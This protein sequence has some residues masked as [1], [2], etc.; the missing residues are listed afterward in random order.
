VRRLTVLE[1]PLAGVFQVRRLRAADAR[2]SFERIFCASELAEAGWRRPIAQVNLTRTATL[3]TVRGMHYQ[4]PPHA[5]T[6]LVTCV[7][8][9]VFDVAVDLREGSP[10]FLRWFGVRLAAAAG[11]ALLIPPGFAH[12]F[13]SLT[14]DVELLYCHDAAYAADAEAG[15]LA[16]DP[17]IGVAWPMLVANLSARD[18][19]HPPL[20]AEFEGVRL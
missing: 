13:Q 14:D 17:R 12:G 9:E 1:T 6:K 8:G 11:D 15:V 2:G 20:S 5:E 19:A 16:T 18:T 4:R 7:R 10:T 3:G